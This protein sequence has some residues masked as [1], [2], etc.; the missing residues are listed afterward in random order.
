MQKKP[1][2]SLTSIFIVT[3]IIVFGLILPLGS[4]VDLS[5]VLE[6]IYSK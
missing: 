1:T 3:I 5:M 4:F 6:I 2:N